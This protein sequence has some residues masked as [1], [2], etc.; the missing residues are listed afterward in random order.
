ML[1]WS[2]PLVSLC[3]CMGWE[4]P[5][6]HLQYLFFCSIFVFQLSGIVCANYA[7]LPSL[8]LR[9]IP[10][11]RE[12]NDAVVSEMFLAWFSLFSKNGFERAINKNREKKILFSEGLHEVASVY[13]QHIFRAT[14]DMAHMQEGGHSLQKNSGPT[15]VIQTPYITP[16]SRH[17]NSCRFLLNKKCVFAR[18]RSHPSDR[19]MPDLMTGSTIFIANLSSYNPSYQLE[20]L[21]V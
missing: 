13:P 11:K 9:T 16:P 3:G 10:D 15:H 18:H 14:K 4:G 1:L 12:K 17:S 5:S 7:Q 8:S 20:N 19:G 2:Y 21:R 6:L